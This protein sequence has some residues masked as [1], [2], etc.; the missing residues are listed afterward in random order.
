[1]IFCFYLELYLPVFCCI[2]GWFSFL[3][4]AKTTVSSGGPP[5]YDVHCCLHSASESDRGKKGKQEM[6]NYS[7]CSATRDSWK[8]SVTFLSTSEQLQQV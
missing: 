2:L 4:A 1:M 8:I 5:A 7:H 3:V 6:V